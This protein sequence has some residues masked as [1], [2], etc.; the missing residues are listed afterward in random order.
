MTLSDIGES[1]SVL[2]AFHI[3]YSSVH[4]T[5]TVFDIGIIFWSMHYNICEFYS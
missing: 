5:I 3:F 4:I 1:L 2:N